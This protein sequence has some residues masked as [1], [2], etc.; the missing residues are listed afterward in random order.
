MPYCVI[1]KL[2]QL[3]AIDF[4]SQLE[5]SCPYLDKTT[6]PLPEKAIELIDQVIDEALRVMGSRQLPTPQQIRVMAQNGYKVTNDGVTIGSAWKSGV[7]HTPKG[8]I[9]F[10]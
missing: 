4:P 3:M 7:I 2:N 9:N 10:W 6:S 5:A 1:N 8:L